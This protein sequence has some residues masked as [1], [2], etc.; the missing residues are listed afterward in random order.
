M[1][2]RLD[3]RTADFPASFHAFLAA[4]REAMADVDAA[5]RSII[6]DVRVRGDEAL[7]QHSRRF[8]RVDLRQIGFKV[9]TE[10]IEI[11]HAACDRKALDALAFACERI[12]QCLAL[13]IAT[14]AAAE[15]MQPIAELAFLQVADEPVDARD[16]FGCG[17][18]SRK[19]EIL[20]H[21]CGGRWTFRHDG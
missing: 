12:E 2:I 18:G 5:V 15:H 14:G 4:K 7:I 3:S 16:R 6:A 17:G 21:A 10:E 11:A 9:R 1:P 8:D 19:S 20:L 13:V